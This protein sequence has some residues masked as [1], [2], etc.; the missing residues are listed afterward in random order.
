[1][2]GLLRFYWHRYSAHRET[3]LHVTRLPPSPRLKC[4]D[5]YPQCHR[6]GRGL[7]IDFASTQH[8]RIPKHN[9]RTR[10]QS[11]FPSARLEQNTSPRCIVW[12]HTPEITRN[13]RR[14]PGGG[15]QK[16]VTKHTRR[17]VCCALSHTLTADTSPTHTTQLFSLLSPNLICAQPPAQLT[18]VHFDGRPSASQRLPQPSRRNPRPSLDRGSSTIGASSRGRS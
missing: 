15:R 10:R 16:K 1:M 4:L 8:T 18:R 7:N 11:D 13:D 14:R 5:T 6:R 2:E 9:G 17:R 3:C 12:R